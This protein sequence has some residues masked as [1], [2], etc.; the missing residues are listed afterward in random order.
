M[1][2]W[3]ASTSAAALVRA[4]TSRACHSHL[5]RRWRSTQHPREKV[6]IFFR[7]LSLTRTG[8]HPRIK[9]EG[10]LR[11]KTLLS[12]G[13]FSSREPVPT[14]LENA[15]DP[16]GWGSSVPLARGAWGTANWDR[17]DD[18]ARAGSRSTHIADATDR[19]PGR[20]GR[21]RVHLCRRDPCP[22]PCRVHHLRGACPY[23][24]LRRVP[25]HRRDRA[26]AGRLACHR[27]L[28]VQAPH[29]FRVRP[30]QR[31]PPPVDRDE[32]C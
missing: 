7:A 32:V 11:L 8:A 1:R 9:S 12:F 17:S 15:M 27:G 25:C 31:H 23:S 30:E 18:H 24:C 22:G 14:S 20:P 26:A 19:F 16:C 6:L 21:G 2:T 4:F 29:Q 10:M 28:H 3:P 13:A 5:S